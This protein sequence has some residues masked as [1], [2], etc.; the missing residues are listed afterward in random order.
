MFCFGYNVYS[1][2]LKKDY[3]EIKIKL[4]KNQ[5]KIIISFWIVG[6]AYNFFVNKDCNYLNYIKILFFSKFPPY[7]E[8]LMTFVIINLILLI[9]FN[10][11]KK[12]CQNDTRILIIILISLIF[13]I[14][15]YKNINFY[16]S[17]LLIRTEKISFPVMPYISLFFVGVYFSKYKPKF[18]IKISIILCAYSLICLILKKCCFNNLFVR[19]PPNFAFITLSFVPLYFYY[20]VA[21]KISTIFEKNKMFNKLILMGRYTLYFL[22]ISNII[23]FIKIWMIDKGL[24]NIKRYDFLLIY[25]EILVFACLSIKLFRFIKKLKINIGKDLK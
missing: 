15:P 12:I 17:E 16:W 7:S 14:L 11:I 1:S 20:Y 4:I 19:F 9:F 22:I 6:I 13:T 23:I 25:I 5:F 21:G 3:K 8:F 2:Y 18:S 10:F 24:I